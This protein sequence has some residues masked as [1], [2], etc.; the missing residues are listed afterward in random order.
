MEKSLEKRIIEQDRYP[1]LAMLLM[2]ILLLSISARIYSIFPFSLGVLII[3]SLIVISLFL[4][5]RMISSSV[6]EDDLLEN[7]REES[8]KRTLRK[9]MKLPLHLSL[10]TFATIL[11]GGIVLA[12]WG[13]LSG[14][15]RLS[16]GDILWL[17]IPVG[18]LIS[19]AR[20]FSI[21]II[22]TSAIGE[23][24][25]GRESIEA[26]EI[27]ARYLS[28]QARATLFIIIITLLSIIIIVYTY[29]SSPFIAILSGSVIA[30]A[31]VIPF[32]NM[33][34][35]PTVELE[36]ELR[37]MSED[38]IVLSQRLPWRDKG[39][40]A[41]WY[42]RFLDELENRFDSIRSEIDELNKRLNEITDNKR[43]ISSNITKISQFITK[44]RTAKD[45][46]A[47]DIE[48]IDKLFS[49]I[50]N[51]MDQISSIFQTTT[52]AGDDTLQIAD[53]NRDE[54]T[55]ANTYLLDISGAVEVSLDMSRELIESM[56]NI[57]EFLD[58]IKNI[59]GRT[60]VLSFNAAI[61][62]ARSG[63]AGRGFSV[64][65]EEMQDLSDGSAKAA[66]QVEESINDIREKLMD[67]SDMMQLNA[68]KI[69]TARDIS[70][71][72]SLAS[73]SMINSVTSLSND[74]AKIREKIENNRDN[75]EKASDGLASML[76]NLRRYSDEVRPGDEFGSEL[77]ETYR[78]MQDDLDTLKG[79]VNRLKNEIKELERRK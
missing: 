77:E 4:T 1:V 13:S 74:I 17:F 40:P 54:V 78:E 72:M 63:V 66:E 11:L 38:G 58:M 34:A 19:L 15:W 60:R 21:S 23:L 46:R 18:I 69:E 36:R 51:S 41:F 79:I 52:R 59:A 42:N 62:A 16:I 49:Q 24:L 26:S 25:K 53:Q 47:H 45:S 3:F 2:L 65:A 32:S 67:F 39:E 73:E 31:T 61:E 8:E 64:V 7:L 55:K 20:Y 14:G 48:D 75:I 9:L 27:R 29:N 37:R 22:S 10:I 70:R 57:E 35:L 33:I 68:E 56:K 12:Y 50:T 71:G 6:M 43:I 28:W 76:E 30:F 44:M 5:T